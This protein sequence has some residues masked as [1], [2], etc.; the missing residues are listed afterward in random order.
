MA[1]IIVKK[2]RPALYSLRG[3]PWKWVLMSELSEV[4]GIS[5]DKLWAN[6]F[7]L[8]KDR[9]TMGVADMAANFANVGILGEICG[10]YSEEG[11]EYFQRSRAG[12]LHE[13]YSG[14]LLV[15][16]GWANDVVTACERGVVR[17]VEV[18]HEHLHEED[19]CPQ[20]TINCFHVGA[21]S[22]AAVG[23]DGDGKPVV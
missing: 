20:G 6:F 21:G 13:V 15:P 23:L 16:A 9:E 4:T 19:S 7:L 17:V 18:F 22:S 10:S 14:Y 1:S 12:F 3:L 2:A 8:S 11:W 5:S